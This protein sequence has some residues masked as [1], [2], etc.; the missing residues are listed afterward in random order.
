MATNNY[1]YSTTDCVFDKHSGN[2]LDVELD[3]LKTSVNNNNMI[4]VNN[5]NYFGNGNIKVYYDDTTYK[6]SSGTVV[7]GIFADI[8]TGGCKV[9]STNCGTFGF[10]PV[11]SSSPN[12][13][14]GASS[15]STN[16]IGRW[17]T[18]YAVNVLNT[19]DAKY[20]EDINYFD[21]GISTYS[22]GATPFL[23]FVKNDLRPA[24]FTYKRDGEAIRTEDLQ[25]G[26]V[27]NDIIGTPV[28]DLFLYNMGTEEDTDIM[29]SQSGYTTVIAKALQ[30]EIAKREELENKYNELLDKVNKLIGGVD[31]E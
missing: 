27:A 5:S 30:E 17:R 25:V 23:D 11:Y 26:F 2:F 16:G 19:S 15:T 28:G 9:R 10:G 21:E 3:L 18:I 31:N 14:L 4:K 29:F 20:K 13:D 24:T 12:I 22:T 7:P 6:N 1:G 8:T